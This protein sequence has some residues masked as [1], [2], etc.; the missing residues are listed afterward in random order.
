MLLEIGISLAATILIFVLYRL[1]LEAS[2]V[3]HYYVGELQERKSILFYIVMF[4]YE[5]LDDY[6]D[7]IWLLASVI[8][9]I[10]FYKLN[11]ILSLESI[12][13]CLFFI[14]IEILIIIIFLAYINYIDILL[15]K[16]EM[17]KYYN[18]KALIIIITI[19]ILIGLFWYNH[20]KYFLAAALFIALVV[21]S[22]KSFKLIIDDTCEYIKFNLHTNFEDILPIIMVGITHCSAVI[23]IYKITQI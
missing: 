13:R 6:S 23:A 11:W 19:L 2:C 5:L 9:W 17:F 22:I 15:G 10:I 18:I 16:K 4:I 7:I 1:Y 20:I 14:A 21:I 3:R 8:L 12:W